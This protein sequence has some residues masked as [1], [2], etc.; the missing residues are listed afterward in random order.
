M[1]PTFLSCCFRTPEKRRI[2]KCVQPISRA[3]HACSKNW[4]LASKPYIRSYLRPRCQDYF[5]IFLSIRV[6][7]FA[8]C[9]ICEGVELGHQPTIGGSL[10]LSPSPYFSKSFPEHLSKCVLF[11]P[12]LVSDSLCTKDQQQ[13]TATMNNSNNKSASR[14]GERHHR[15]AGVS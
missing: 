11:L 14:P 9:V 6:I 15:L 8:C 7:F 5:I 1:S 13:T 10:S 3:A 2:M 12:G 4:I